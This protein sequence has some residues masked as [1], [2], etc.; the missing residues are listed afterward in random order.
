[1]GGKPGQ[2]AG[3]PPAL[4]QRLA[5]EPG[6]HPYHIHGGCRQELL[7][8]RAH[9]A[10]L[11]TPAEI[12]APDPLREATL[13]PCAQRIRRGELRRLLALPCG[14]KRL[15]VGLRPDRQLAGRCMRGGARLAG[16]TGATG[17]PVKPDADDRTPRH[18]TPRP[19]GTVH[20]LGVPIDDKGLE[21][22][23]F[24]GPPLPAVGPKRRTNY[25]DLMRPL[26]GDQ[27]VGIHIAG[28]EQVGPGEEITIG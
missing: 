23:A 11:P 28:V 20:L 22:I 6:D 15:M 17:G 3:L 24:S 18:I 2:V 13:N 25:I 19:P 4:P 12:K 16:G 1:M 8:L 7:E 26:G 21:V 14:L 5:P 10:Q 9:Q 27:E